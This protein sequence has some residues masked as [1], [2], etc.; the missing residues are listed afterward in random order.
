[1]FFCFVLKQT[2]L[3]TTIHESSNRGTRG[4]CVSNTKT[5]QD[6]SWQG[7]IFQ[8]DNEKECWNLL[9][10]RLGWINYSLKIRRSTPR[11]FTYVWGNLV[12]RRSNKQS[13][14]TWSSAKVEFRA[15]AHGICE[16]IWL[17]RLPVELK[18]PLEKPMKMFC[19]NQVAISIVKNL[20]HH[21][22]TKHVET[23]CHFIKEKMK[24]RI[25]TLIYTPAGLQT[26]DV[27]AK[28]LPTSNFEDLSCKLGM[29]N[30]YSLA[31]GREWNFSFA[32][33]VIL[34]MVFT[35]VYYFCI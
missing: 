14:V 11:Y 23:N 26:V 15:V 21:D 7:P 8:E 25:I 4:S 5:S 1:M 2:F 34:Q 24:E 18:I 28:A 13:V 3:Y 6:H 32:F 29:I 33:S 9:K 35:V 22:W 17:V 12:G 31:W 27:L 10:C 19:D 20:V 16:G 30:I